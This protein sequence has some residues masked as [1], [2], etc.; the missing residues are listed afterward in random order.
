MR[1]TDELIGCARGRPAVVIGGGPS[2]P[3]DLARLGSDEAGAIY[4]SSNDHG[5]R[6]RPC[7]FA[8]A[9][10]DLEAR[11]RT[12]PA[13]IVARKDWAD[14]RPVN[15]PRNNSGRLAAWLARLLGCAPIYLVGMDCYGGE[16]YFHAPDAVSCGSL[17]PV[18]QHV[19]EWATFFRAW[20][21]DYRALSG[22]L[23]ELVPYRSALEEPGRPVDDVSPSPQE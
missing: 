2:A 22:P 20:P 12:A 14:V 7:H 16:T 23:S 10:D 8:C 9:V 4:V 19:A 6:L 3:E 13:V 1:T 15:F 17:Q 5:Y 21:G 18:R 11:L